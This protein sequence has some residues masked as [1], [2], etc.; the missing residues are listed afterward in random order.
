MTSRATLLADPMSGARPLASPARVIPPGRPAT[1]DVEP[2]D[3][4]R[5][6]TE[7]GYLRD[8]CTGYIGQYRLS[9]PRDQASFLTFTKITLSARKSSDSAA[10]RNTRHLVTIAQAG[11]QTK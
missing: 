1:W 11:G 8:H 3:A 9:E 5:A 10:R 4:Y 7:W 6:G 2:A